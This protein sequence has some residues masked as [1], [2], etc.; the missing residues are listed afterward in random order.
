[1]NKK[2]R[3]QLL[4]GVGVF[5]LIILIAF[6]FI[7]R[8]PTIAAQL[9]VERGQVEVNGETVTETTDLSE[10]DTIETFQSLA[11][12]ILYE[13]LV[14]NLEQNTKITLTDLLQSHPTVEQ[15]SGSTWNKFTGLLG[16]ESYTI[17]SGNTFASVRGTHFLFTEDK[18]FTEEGSVDYTIGGKNYRVLAG[19]VVEKIN[20]RINQRDANQNELGLVQQRKQR[21]VNALQNLRELEMAK[22]PIL[23]K[24]IKRAYSLDNHQVEQIFREADQGLYDVDKTIEASPYQTQSVK[25]VAAITKK[26]QE[27]Q[28][29]QP[30]Q[31]QRINSPRVI[32]QPQVDE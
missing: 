9:L 25:K 32:S 19:K 24:T 1:M 11:T 30:H 15:E 10:G 29:T 12:V 31:I 16:M 4:I 28:G 17:E 7:N 6:F 26:I 18:V 3:K 14:I 22:H 27:I 21:A 5:I 2:L 23:F 13:S 20:G 8:S